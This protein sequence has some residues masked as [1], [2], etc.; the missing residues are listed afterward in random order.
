MKSLLIAAVGLCLSAS[1]ALAQDVCPPAKVTNV[2]VTTGKTTAT[3]SFTFS[4]DDCNTGNATSFL[5]LK[6]STSFNDSN[7]GNATIMLNTGADTQGSSDCYEFGPTGLSCGQTYYWA[8][9]IVDDAGNRT[10]SNV[11]QATQ[12]GCGSHQEVICP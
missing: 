7:W 8:V 4:G 5:V 9:V 12:L 6:S 2:V 1:I 3:V 11:V 10:L